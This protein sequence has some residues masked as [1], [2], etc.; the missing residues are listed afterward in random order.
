MIKLVQ[1]PKKFAEKDIRAG[2]TEW[3][4]IF[5]KRN[6][7]IFQVCPWLDKKHSAPKADMLGEAKVEEVP[8]LDLPSLA[9]FQRS[10]LCFVT[11]QNITENTGW[12]SPS[13]SELSHWDHIRLRKAFEL[14]NYDSDIFQPEGILQQKYSTLLWHWTNRADGARKFSD[15]CCRNKQK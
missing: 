10:I 11:L 5:F 4:I 9:A 15:S 6:K 13:S 8:E 2:I 1:E 12:S 14:H 3:S 7:Y